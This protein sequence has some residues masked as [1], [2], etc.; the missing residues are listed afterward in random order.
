M[1]AQLL[2]K[3]YALQNAFLDCYAFLFRFKFYNFYKDVKESIDDE[4]LVELPIHPPL[5]KQKDLKAP[6]D[7]LKPIPTYNDLFVFTKDKQPFNKTTRSFL[8]LCN[9]LANKLFS[10]SFTKHIAFIRINDLKILK[11]Q[12]SK[13]DL[14]CEY[15]GNFKSL[16]L[17]KA[18]EVDKDFAY[19]HLDI[20]IFDKIGE[21][22]IC[23]LNYTLP[24]HI[25]NLQDSYK[26]KMYFI[27]PIFMF[28]H[29]GSLHTAFNNCS[30]IIQDSLQFLVLG[31]TQGCLS[32]ADTAKREKTIKQNDL[33]Y[34]L[35]KIQRHYPQTYYFDLIDVPG[36]LKAFR[37]VEELL[38]L[39][40]E[41]VLK[42][43][44]FYQARNGYGYYR[45][46]KPFI[47]RHK[48]FNIKTALKSLIAA[49][50]VLFA[51][52]FI[53]LATSKPKVA[54]LI[55]QEEIDTKYKKLL[56]ASFDKNYKPVYMQAYEKMKTEKT[57]SINIDNKF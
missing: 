54:S 15:K 17:Y 26:D 39:E 42:L 38:N 48:N 27:N 11:A 44:S 20:K 31:Y 35:T 25:Q 50:V 22:Y 5:N 57:Q 32:F 52:P 36:I 51:L 23:H 34:L 19:E 8:I 53:E 47:T 12:V 16:A 29:L 9:I 13:K 6:L 55:S 43:L 28:S 4:L 2:N 46:Q 1:A 3:V 7:S 37:S 10:K 18:Y 14:N 33:A 45:F 49:S 41:D 21:N 40:K 30:I 24:G 56:K